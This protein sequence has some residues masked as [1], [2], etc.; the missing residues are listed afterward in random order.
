[1]VPEILSLWFPLLSCSRRRRWSLRRPRAVT[2][3]YH[4]EEMFQRR[5]KMNYGEDPILVSMAKVPISNLLRNP[6]LLRIF[7]CILTRWSCCC[8]SRLRYIN[9]RGLAQ[10]SICT[11]G[12]LAHLTTLPHVLESGTK[13]R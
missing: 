12:T 11:W 13:R 9:P 2:N 7:F 4:K 10:E 6:L 8:R 1:L 3:Q 5:R